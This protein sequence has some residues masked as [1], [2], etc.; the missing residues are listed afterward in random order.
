MCFP[1]IFDKS[2]LSTESTYLPASIHPMHTDVPRNDL[3]A[4]REEASMTMF[5][6]VQVRMSMF[7]TVLVCVVHLVRFRSGD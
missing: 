2:G 3:N 5:G 1:Q 7:G 6:A 4:A